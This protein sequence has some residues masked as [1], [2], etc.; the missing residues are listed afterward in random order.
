MKKVFTLFLSIFL[1]PLTANAVVTP[2]ANVVSTSYVK[3]AVDALDTTKQDKLTSTN[4]VYDANGSNNGFISAV[5]ANNGTV[6]VTKSEVT[7]PVG[8]QSSA[9]RA[10]I[11]V[12]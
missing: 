7:I 6:T 4:V 8:S 10:A 9:T 3:G 1:I 12:Q 5:T 11:W 2:E